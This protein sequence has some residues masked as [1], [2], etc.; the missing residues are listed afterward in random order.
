MAGQTKT[1]VEAEWSKAAEALEKVKKV[2]LWGEFWNFVARG[3]VIDMAVGVIIGAAFGKIVSSL[4]DD[5]LMP[6]LGVLLNGIDF[7]DLSWQIGDAKIAYGMFIQNV[8]DFLI[9]AVCIFLIVKAL[10]KV[11]AK[12]DKAAAKEPKKPTLEE[13]QLAI[14][15]EIR[16]NL[17]KH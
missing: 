1:K 8:M 2:P 15:R 17:R 12:K 7:S 6:I 9:M 11:T 10:G 5:I 14:L 13:Q 3:N 4:V 16:D